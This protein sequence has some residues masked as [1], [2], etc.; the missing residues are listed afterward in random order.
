[1]KFNRSNSPGVNDVSFRESLILN[2]SKNVLK[3]Y[4]SL[5]IIG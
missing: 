1:M 4:T 5:E 3:N 2:R